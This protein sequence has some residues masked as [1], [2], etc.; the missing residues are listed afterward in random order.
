MPK[1][2]RQLCTIPGLAEA[3]RNEEMFISKGGRF[4]EAVAAYTETIRRD[5]KDPRAY[6]NRTRLLFEIGCH[7]GKFKGLR[8]CHPIDANFIRAYIRKAALQYA[9]RD[10]S[11]CLETCRRRL[12]STRNTS[13]PPKSKVKRLKPLSKFT[14]NNN[15][16]PKLKVAPIIR[17]NTIADKIA[18]TPNWLQL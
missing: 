16:L 10:Y 12:P 17:R 15:K 18:R 1:G 3:A 5:E 8:P 13:T 14:A 2:P 4:V 9:K 6:S 11:E 7:P